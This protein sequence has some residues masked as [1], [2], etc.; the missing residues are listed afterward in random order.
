[1]Y[2][3]AT[4]VESFD[5]LM[6]QQKD[7]SIGPACVGANTAYAN[8]LADAMPNLQTVDVIN[9]EDGFRQALVDGNCTVLINAEHAAYHFIKNSA[10]KDSCEID[11][12]PVGII[13]D[14]LSYGLT[15]MAIGF[16]SDTP[17][18]TIDAISYYLNELMT[19]APNTDGCDGS[20][21]TSWIKNAGTG[22]DC[23]YNGSGGGDSSTT[24]KSSGGYTDT[25]IGYGTTLIKAAMI[26]F[27]V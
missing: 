19:C 1:M 17:P 8:W 4:G 18:E 7:G 16:N 26:S 12:T 10:A 15:Q 9:T 24:D 25:I 20:L 5:D 23:G 6:G 27:L 3:T 13:G 11:G 2:G 22:N 14:G 21:Y